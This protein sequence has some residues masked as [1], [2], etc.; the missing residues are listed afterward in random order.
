MPLAQVGNSQ[1][2]PLLTATTTLNPGQSGIPGPGQQGT[3]PTTYG[4]LYGVYVPALGTSTTTGTATA[5]N[6]IGVSLYDV[7]S[8][9]FQ[10]TNTATVTNLL[11]NGT[12]TANGA[13]FVAGLQGVGVR[14]KGALVAVLSGGTTFSGQSVNVGW[15]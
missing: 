6:P 9:N 5:S 12:A 3:L 15:D 14:Y 11:L 1:Y 4:V 10:G 7:I 2:T 13:S 8:P